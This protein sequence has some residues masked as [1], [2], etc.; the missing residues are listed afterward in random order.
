MYCDRI[1]FERLMRV[2]LIIIVAHVL[3]IHHDHKMRSTKMFGQSQTMI[4]IHFQKRQS[5]FPEE[6]QQKANAKKVLIPDT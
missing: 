2:L 1:A 4:D 6:Q 5:D 3:Y